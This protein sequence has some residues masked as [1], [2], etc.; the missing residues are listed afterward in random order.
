MKKARHAASFFGGVMTVLL[1]F[2][3]LTTALAAS[4]QV[5]YNFSNVSLNG[6]RKIVAGTEITAANGQ[7]V[8]SS[9]LYTDAAGGKTNYLPIRTISE[10]LGV[11]ID[12]D[13]TTKTVLLGEQPSDSGDWVADGYTG[14]IIGP[15][16]TRT[17]VPHYSDLFPGQEL[18]KG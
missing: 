15:D 17:E 6:E 9:I 3:C 10:L 13:S 16:G 18:P 1:A 12:Y 14:Y 5:T 2:G 4:G 11:E 8:P 7:K